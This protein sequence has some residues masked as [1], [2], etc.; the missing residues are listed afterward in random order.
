[1]DERLEKFVSNFQYDT[2]YLISK[3]KY[4]DSIKYLPRGVQ[5][6]LISLILEKKLIVSKANNIVEEITVYYKLNGSM[7]QLYVIFSTNGRFIYFET[8]NEKQTKY[9]NYSSNNSWFMLPIQSYGL[10]SLI[11]YECI[12]Y[13]DKYYPYLALSNLTLSDDSDVPKNELRRNKLYSNF[14]YKIVNYKAYHTNLI[15]YPLDKM[16]GFNRFVSLRNTPGNIFRY[17]D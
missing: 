8:Y 9:D 12:A 15:K 10:G 7:K 5:P 1:M 16:F 13:R 3:Y 4:P 14:G 6:E 2:P 11:L 17:L